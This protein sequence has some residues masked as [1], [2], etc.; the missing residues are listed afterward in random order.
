[1]NTKKF[2][3]QYLKDNKDTVE[4]E[5]GNL[6]WWDKIK[7]KWQL[8]PELPSYHKDSG[9]YLS[10][11]IWIDKL[12]DSYNETT[13]K[14]KKGKAYLF[15]DQKY[16]GGIRVDNNCYEYNWKI[17]TVESMRNSRWR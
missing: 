1:M 6:S 8:L 5:L 4:E 2:T 9:Q 12:T 3:L 17:G 15:I 13:G 14:P 7:F 16:P 11:K 10:W